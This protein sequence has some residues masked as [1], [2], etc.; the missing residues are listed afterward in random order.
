MCEEY[1]KDRDH[2]AFCYISK[3]NSF[4][5]SVGAL[6]SILDMPS[7]DLMYMQCNSGMTQNFIAMHTF[8]DLATDN[9]VMYVDSEF[10]NVLSKVSSSFSRRL[11]ILSSMLS[12]ISAIHS[13]LMKAPEQAPEQEPTEASE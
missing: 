1:F 9:I 13:S 7:T 11:S 6:L 8:V 5:I 4:G 3:S 2:V 12:N 10:I